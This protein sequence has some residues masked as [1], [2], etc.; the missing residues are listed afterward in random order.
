M[1]VAALEHSLALRAWMAAG[2]AWI[3]SGHVLAAV[4]VAE[5]TSSLGFYVILFLRRYP[6]FPL[7]PRRD[8]Q[9]GHGKSGRY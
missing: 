4:E 6:L 3:A 8:P 7:L 9:R 5:M 1:R 2:L